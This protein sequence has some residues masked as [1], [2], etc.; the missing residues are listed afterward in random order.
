MGLQEKSVFSAQNQG[1]FT[2]SIAAVTSIQP[3]AELKLKIEELR[4][5]I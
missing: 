4:L 1:F 2:T 3:P 5:K